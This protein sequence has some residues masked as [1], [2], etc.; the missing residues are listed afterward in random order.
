MHTHKQTALGEVESLSQN[1]RVLT[2]QRER[3]MAE[4]QALER[5][6]ADLSLQCRALLREVEDLR[7]S[8]ASPAVQ[9]ALIRSSN[10][11]GSMNLSSDENRVNIPTSAKDAEQVITE[12]LVVFKSVEDLQSQNL[13][14][15]R[16]VRQLSTDQ[17]RELEE[18]KR[19]LKKEYAGEW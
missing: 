4:I 17:D 8:M 13:N 3:F 18:R 11:D 2:L 9:R 15:L 7:S 6:R 19:D 14:L 5:E 12:N 16:V 1:N 10:H